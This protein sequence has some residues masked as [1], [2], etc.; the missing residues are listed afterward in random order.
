MQSADGLSE[1]VIDQW[2]QR[3]RISTL[4]NYHYEMG[5][6]L[7]RTGDRENAIGQMRKAAGLMP[8]HAVARFELEALLLSTGQAPS[9]TEQLDPELRFRG[10][11][12]HIARALA[13]GRFTDA[14]KDLSTAPDPGKNGAVIGWLRALTLFMARGEAQDK[15]DGPITDA[16]AALLRPVGDFVT[17][18]AQK[19]Q[20]TLDP[21][22]VDYFR[23]YLALEPDNPAALQGLTTALLAAGHHAELRDHIGTLPITDAQSLRHRATLW[24]GLDEA[25][26]ALTDL[27]S[28]REET[29]HG[30]SLVM[31]ACA[32]LLLGRREEAHPLIRRAEELLPGRAW[33]VATRAW[34]ETGGT[35]SVPVDAGVPGIQTVL[36]RLPTRISAL[37]DPR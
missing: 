22:A 5:L 7:A 27:D 34:Y 3:I 4:A 33:T 37:L 26:K 11:V 21:A 20:G 10:F 16:V 9:D 17:A 8:D 15:P 19:C 14:E 32:L 23:L 6:A 36:A 31:R 24:I 35:R 12:E 25:G 29:P 30:M 28:L 18:A 1:V 2:R 13:D